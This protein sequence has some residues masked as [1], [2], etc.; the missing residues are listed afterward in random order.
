MK[1]VEVELPADLWAE[2][3][4][5]ASPSAGGETA[6]VV[7]AVREKL[8]ACAEIEYLAARAARGDRTAFDRVLAKVPALPPMQGD[9]R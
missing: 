1:G 3:A 9:E 7:A 8:A 5:R 4:R 6:W 2:V